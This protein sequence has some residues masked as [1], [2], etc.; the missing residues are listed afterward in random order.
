MNRSTDK[1][2][3]EIDA[4]IHSYSQEIVEK[5]FKRLTQYHLKFRRAMESQKGSSSEM[6]SDAKVK[7]LRARL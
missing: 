3:K 6:D 5:F 4:E 7:G 2:L 1:I